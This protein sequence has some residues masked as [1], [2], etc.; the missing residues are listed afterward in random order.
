MSN[1]IGTDS[2]IST[3]VNNLCNE[4]Q[5]VRNRTT[6]SVHPNVCY[7][8]ICFPLRFN[9][10]KTDEDKLKTRLNLYPDNSD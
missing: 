10:V 8:P 7:C 6:E 9:S 1:K 4:F 3:S 2:I 5:E